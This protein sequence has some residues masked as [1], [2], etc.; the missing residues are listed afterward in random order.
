MSSYFYRTIVLAIAVSFLAIRLPA[1]DTNASPDSTNEL[2]NDALT[3]SLLQIQEQLHNTQLALQENQQVAAALARSNSDMLTAHLQSL[4]QTLNTQR[5]EEAEEAHK[6]AEWTLLLTGVIGLAGL[7]I[8]LWMVYLQTRAFTKLTEISIQQNAVMANASAVHQL[9]APARA[10]VENSNAKLLEVV[11]QLKDRITELELGTPSLPIG[12]KTNGIT[13]GNGNGR[14]K[15][16]A[17]A[18]GQQHLD[19]NEPQQALEIIDRYLAGHP[20]DP[21]AL[22]KKADALQKIGRN[23]EALAHYNRVI[24]ADSSMA[25]AHLQKGGLL[26]RL[27]RYDEALNCYEQ[28]LQ[29]QEKKRR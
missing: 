15:A 19:Q 20:D 14:P 11:G 29:A 21:E 24:A 16:E 12:A 2:R 7:G 17:L 25:V 18:E 6:T 23:D 5:A 9:A 4:E 22:L 3:A 10:V 26:N 28:A 8:L 1:M 27:R 13:N